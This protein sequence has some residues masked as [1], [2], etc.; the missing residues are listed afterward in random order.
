M[1]K[2]TIAVVLVLLIIIVIWFVNLLWSAGQFKTIEP[3]FDG[4]CNPIAGLSGAEDITIHPKTGIAYISACDRR[5]VNAG[6]AGYGAIYAYSLNATDPIL[7]NLTSNMGKDFQPHGISLYVDDNGKGFLF[8]INHGRDV[9]TIEVFELIGMLLYHTKT[10]S[11]PMLVSPNDLVAVGPD[12]FYVSNDHGYTSGI[13]RVMEDYLKLPY[14]N[15]VYYDG[16]RFSEAA[17]G[18]RYANGINVSRDGKTLYLCSVT[19]LSLHLYDRELSSG[20]LN[21]REKIK[22][23]TGVDNIEVDPSGGLWIGA[24]PRILDF[25]AHANDPSRLSPSQI[26]YLSPKP[27]G[28]FNIK[29]VYLNKGDEL[30][31]SSVAAVR[32]KRMLIGGVFDPKFL[33]CQMEETESK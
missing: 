2:K 10:I 27:S 26:L 8:A 3:H 6:K 20:K 25:V 22:L 28:G 30:S 19:G 31:A 21:L 1:F 9:H 12:S 14:S 15:V 11:D 32:G 29:E 13:M 17:G 33:D 16:S 24:H 23:G 4:T 5:A 18:I 7:F